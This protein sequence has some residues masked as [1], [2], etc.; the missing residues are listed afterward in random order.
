MLVSQNHGS[1]V[2]ALLSE[3]NP[4]SNRPIVSQSSSRVSIGY[5]QSSKLGE[6]YTTTQPR[7]R[8]NDIRGPCP[9]RVILEDEVNQPLPLDAHINY[10]QTCE[11]GHDIRI[12]NVGMVDPE[13]HRNLLR[14]SGIAHELEFLQDEL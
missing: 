5:T 13:H 3:A 14:D 1:Q 12:I 10:A 2:D 6:I 7:P 11:I 4:N 9:L 8:S